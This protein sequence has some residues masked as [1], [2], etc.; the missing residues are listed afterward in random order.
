MNGPVQRQIRHTIQEAEIRRIRRHIDEIDDTAMFETYPPD[1]EVQLGRA[2][3][4][5]LY[6]ESKQ[7][8]NH[9][10]ASFAKDGLSILSERWKKVGHAAT[11]TNGAR[12]IS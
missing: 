6:H 7:T 10:R 8:K 1:G 4:S 9:E 12:T 5:R 11:C 3:L 2:V